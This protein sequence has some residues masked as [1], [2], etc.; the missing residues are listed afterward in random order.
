MR[1][2]KEQAHLLEN[3]VE[4]LASKTDFIIKGLLHHKIN[5]KKLPRQ[6]RALRDEGI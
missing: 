3:Q 4:F 2:K 5:L 6:H 1:G